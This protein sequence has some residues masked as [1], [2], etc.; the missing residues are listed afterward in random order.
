MTTGA[1]VSLDAG[2]RGAGWSVDGVG[3]L[4]LNT[5]APV[6]RPIAIPEVRKM[7]V[8]SVDECVSS[9]I[10]RVALTATVASNSMGTRSLM[11]DF[12]L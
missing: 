7:A 5:R 4:R 11:G 3:E 6:E 12:V 8:I 9:Q 2:S 10:A 1:L